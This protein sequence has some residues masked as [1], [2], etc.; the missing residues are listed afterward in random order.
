MYC[1]PIAMYIFNF[2]VFSAAYQYSLLVRAAIQR[3]GSIFV[4]LSV[5]GADTIA[6]DLALSALIS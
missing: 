3:R 6:I 2:I 4:I 5:Y 1:I